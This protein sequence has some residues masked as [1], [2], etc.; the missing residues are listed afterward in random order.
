M[1]ELPHAVFAKAPPRGLVFLNYA[2]NKMYDEVY[3]AL[4]VD[5]HA[6]NVRLQYRAERRTCGYETSQTRGTQRG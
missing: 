4:D 6:M 5:L 1:F 3:E 2:D